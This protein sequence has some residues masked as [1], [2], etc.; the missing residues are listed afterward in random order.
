VTQADGSYVF[1]GCVTK[2]DGGKTDVTSTQSN[3]DGIDVSA[4]SSDKATYDDGT[5]VGHELITSGVATLS[6]ALG[7]T[8]TSIFKGKVVA[9]LDGKLHFALP[10]KT[11]VAGLPVSGTLTV[12]PAKKDGKASGTATATVDTTLPPALG[13]G[14][15]KLTAT[16]MVNK[17]I[18]GVKVTADKASFLQLFKLSSVVIKYDSTSKGAQTWSV[19]A[20]ASAGGKAS[21][22]FSGS[23]T[24]SGGKLT[25][26]S[27]SV[28]KTSLAGL[29]DVTSLKVTDSNGTWT[30]HAETGTGTN[31]KTLDIM[32]AF[33]DS[34]L[35]SGSIEASD[36]SVFGVL[37]VTTFE[38]SYS[39]S[40][41]SIA[42]AA[43]DGGGASGSMT[44]TDGVI[45]RGSL[46]VKDV[47]F[48]GKFTVATAEVSYA[49]EE[50]NPAC[51]DVH[52]ESIWC[53]D[54]QVQLPSAS[55]VTGISGKLAVADGAFASGSVD[56]QGN[57]PLLDGLFLTKL[58]GGVTVNPPPTTI[59]G[60]AGLR[61]GP[62]IKGTS[63]LD[64]DGDLTRQ[65]PGDG[66]SGAYQLNG[67]LRNAR[68]EAGRLRVRLGRRPH[69]VRLDGLQGGRL[70]TC[71]GK[72]SD[73]RARDAGR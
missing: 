62:Q 4:S 36:I 6:L 55:A 38:L 58:G 25:A 60:T 7:G 31:A 54:W 68:G 5:S 1:G 43:A 32:L 20:Q 52:G 19:S 70:L 14:K 15:A 18:T 72:Q 67:R 53:G 37:D 65:L 17:G 47:S 61:F 39:A 3:V 63:V 59:S 8:L 50:P 12:A 13:G 71:P 9:G 57:V 69:L 26:A 23:L 45:A 48:L 16:T 33:G 64:F 24:Y 66:T 29:V 42:I 22:P 56:V 46:K 44:A 2:E 21:T 73:Y 35:E 10:K 34:G 41:W 27:L 11:V 40:A 30:G 28:G 49:Q 51:G